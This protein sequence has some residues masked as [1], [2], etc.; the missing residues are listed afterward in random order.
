MVRV[1]V[2][3]VPWSGKKDHMGIVVK[4]FNTRGFSPES[5]H[6]S[7]ACDVLVNNEVRTFLVKWIDI[8]NES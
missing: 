7:P 8:V 3:S 4:T 5:E 6:S 1:P 2:G